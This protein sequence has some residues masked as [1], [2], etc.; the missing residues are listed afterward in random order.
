M[1]KHIATQESFATDKIQALREGFIKTDEK[2][3]GKYE[4]DGCTAV[5][6]ILTEDNQLY[7]AHAGDSRCVLSTVD[8][9]ASTPTKD[10]KPNDEIEKK[11]IESTV[12]EV[13]KDT[14][15]FNGK[16]VFSYR[17]DGIISVSRS[18]GDLNFKDNQELGPEAQAICCI[19][20]ISQHT[21][22]NGQLILLA[23]D[24]LWDVMTD[25]QA[26]D[27][28]LEGRKSQDLQQVATSLLEKAIELGSAD[29]ITIVIISVEDA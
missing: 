3:L 12:H 10:H 21:I 20:D 25:Q 18:I 27:F 9:K 15:L 8:G 1:P 23:C 14:I 17:I 24:G 7:I 2:Y 22:R 26:V 29:N 5:V 13:Q 19:P 16:R 4:E 28:I 11:R 6:A